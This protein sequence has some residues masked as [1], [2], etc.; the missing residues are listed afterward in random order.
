MKKEQRRHSASVIP[1]ILGVKHLGRAP[2]DKGG[3]ART[4]RFTISAPPHAVDVDSE[5]PET[6]VAVAK[7][8]RPVHI[9]ATSGA[10]ERSASFRVINIE[11]VAT[12]PALVH[13]DVKMA[14]IDHLPE[15]TLVA[16][17]RSLLSMAFK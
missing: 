3:A 4:D 9:R 6:V 16:Q 5:K 8:I 11:P 12:C 10:D 7:V 14:V 2:S 1:A 17:H 15:A 13:L